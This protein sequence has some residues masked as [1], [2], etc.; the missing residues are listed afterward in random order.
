[1]LP[2]TWISCS[3]QK[4]TLI[5]L[6]SKSLLPK[7]SLG[8]QR[9]ALTSEWLLLWTVDNIMRNKHLYLILASWKDHLS[10]TSLILG[11]KI[12]VTIMSCRVH[13]F[14]LSENWHVILFIFETLMVPHH[15]HFEYFS[16]LFT[17]VVIK[18]RPNKEN[19]RSL[20]QSEILNKKLAFQVSEDL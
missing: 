8:I 7:L 18:N 19:W 12:L 13:F 11:C 5:P 20:L 1:M 3:W 17:L 14:G 2:P 10:S 15:T 9:S 16:K 6:T 4:T